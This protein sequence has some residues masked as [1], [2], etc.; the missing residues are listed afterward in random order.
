MSETLTKPDRA[1]GRTFTQSL[2]TSTFDGQAFDRAAGLFKGFPA[3]CYL[4]HSN[5]LHPIGE[6]NEKKGKEALSS[7]VTLSM[8]TLVLACKSQRV[9]VRVSSASQEGSGLT[10]Q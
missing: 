10:L 3:I 4:P 1:A 2:L 6:R 5:G 8:A 7:F 9:Q